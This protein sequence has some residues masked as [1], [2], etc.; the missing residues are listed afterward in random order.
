MNIDYLNVCNIDCAMTLEN[1][2]LFSRL[3]LNPCEDR[4]EWWLVSV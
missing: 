1:G 4:E 2:T 3:Q